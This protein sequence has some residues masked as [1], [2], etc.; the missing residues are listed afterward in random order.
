MGKWESAVYSAVHTHTSVLKSHL[1]ALLLYSK[2]LN[3]AEEHFLT[4]LSFK[5]SC[6]IS[7]LSSAGS[8][9]SPPIKSSIFVCA[10]LALILLRMAR[11]TE[12][13]VSLV[14]D[15]ISRSSTWRPWFGKRTINVICFPRNALQEKWCKKVQLKPWRDLVHL[16]AKKADRKVFVICMSQLLQR[17]YVRPLSITGTENGFRFVL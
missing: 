1:I 12:P 9:T 8:T 6:P 11:R 4:V 16:K 7:F 3:S 14:C 17:L 10:A 5:L 15:Q 2:I 13:I